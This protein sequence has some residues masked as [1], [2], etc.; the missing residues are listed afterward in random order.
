[1]TMVNNFEVNGPV[2]MESVQDLMNTKIPGIP[3]LPSEDEIEEA[4][5]INRKPNK[6][7]SN[8]KLNK[9]NKQ[10][11]LQPDD[12]IINQGKKINKSEMKINDDNSLLNSLC[13][14]FDKIFK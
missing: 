6:I 9:P 10:Q 7:K 2:S 3:I 12:D 11:I 1:M 13:I 4:K 5:L 8:L 14:K